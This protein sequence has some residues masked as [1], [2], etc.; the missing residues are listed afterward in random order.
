MKDASARADSGPAALQIG[1]KIVVLG[2]AVAVAGLP[3][4][5]IGIFALLGLA[6]VVIVSGVVRLKAQAWGAAFAIVVVGIGAQAVFAPPTIDEGFNV[7]MPGGA[8]ERELPPDVY[9]FLSA[10][11]D[12]QYPADKRCDANASGC[13]R[14]GEPLGRAFAFSPDG[15]FHPSEL[16]RAVTSL[17]ST[18]PAM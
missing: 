10:Q 2:L 3:V 14:H 16:S 12:K 5:S 18:T 15:I 1:L 11:F 13:W 9:R 6:A 4:N 7:F 17:T 8:L